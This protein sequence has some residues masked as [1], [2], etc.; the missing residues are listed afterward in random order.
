MDGVR[1]IAVLLVMV[2]HFGLLYASTHRNLLA[3]AIS[4]GWSGVDLFFVLSGFLITTILVET[5]SDPHFFRN[6]YLRR[7]LRILPLY[8]AYVLFFAFAFLPVAHHFK[9]FTAFHVGQLSLYWV[10]LS[11]WSSAWG[12]LENS[13]VGHMWS[14]AI[15]EQF[16]FFWPLLVFVL[17]EGIL[18]LICLALSAA[19]IRLRLSPAMQA[20]HLVHTNFLYRLTPFRIESIS[21]GAIIALLN[22]QSQRRD[23]RSLIGWACL[24]SGLGLLWH[25][26]SAGHT[27]DDRSLNIA[28]LGYTAV[29]LCAAGIILVALRYQGSTAFYARLL[30]SSVLRAFG[31][32]SYAMYIFHFALSQYMGG[33]V[34]RFIGNPLM[35]L[36]VSCSLGVGLCFVLAK[37]SW[38]YFES[39]ILAL[40]D[41]IAGYRKAVDFEAPTEE[42]PAPGL[43]S[44]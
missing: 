30:R 38:K 3:S 32:Y 11:N 23:V 33:A 17:P 19:A 31:K 28:T 39:P 1:G 44:V 34:A 13:P 29:G 24:I 43:A 8:Y 9:K 12:V 41:R 10:H 16:Y 7:G 42:S 40:K 22:R 6:F 5:R 21:Y 4:L 26:W 36:I 25:Q 27:F 35:A 15:E 2:Y 14:L 18:L 20:I 37:V